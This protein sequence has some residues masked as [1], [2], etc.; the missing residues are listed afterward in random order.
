MT[1]WHPLASTAALRTRAALLQEARAF[2]AAR[3]VLE[4]TTPVLGA[5]ATTE[6]GIASMALQ[7]PAWWLRTSPEYHMKRLLA[8]GAPDIYQIGP[9]FRAGETG[10]RHHPEFTL[11]EWYRRG[12]TLDDLIGECCALLNALLV[13]GGT[14]AQA[15]EIV[16]YT[17]VF[18]AIT[19]LDP[20]TATVAELQRFARGHADYDPGLA[21]T[22]GDDRAAWLDLLV[23]LVV[24]PALPH[25]RLLV[26]R[27]FPADQAMLARLHP[28]DARVAERFEVFLRG[29]ELAN[30]FRELT[31][32]AEQRR[33]FVADN[34]RRRA[35]GLP[36]MALD[37]LLLDAL[38]AGLPDC[39]GVAVGLE[40]VHMLAAGAASLDAVT[41]FR[42]GA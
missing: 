1:D 16:T 38:D 17:E 25:D 11:V 9:V 18:A 42:S 30:G 39:S 33:R 22:L 10:R 24:Y 15:V 41:G 20:L 32:A 4:V 37:T 27:N 23:G 21:T 7:E 14:G 8:A 29:I 3:A 13:T 40:R 19:G 31:D 5:C 12:F 34:A 35:R 26:I 6:A 2:F 28:D 36:E